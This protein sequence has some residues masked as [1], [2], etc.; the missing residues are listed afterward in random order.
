MVPMTPEQIALVESTFASLDVETLAADFYFRA[1]NADTQLSAMFTTDP[2]V[3]RTRFAKE[4]GVIVSSIRHLDDFRDETRELGRRHRDYGVRA[5]HYRVMGDALLA[6]LAAALGESWDDE[7][8]EAW[9]MAF[10]LTAESMLEGAGP[11]LR[12]PAR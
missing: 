10:N 3:Q 6:A 5:G 11:S 7:T 12:D 9:R 2:A 8:E 1:F 4:L